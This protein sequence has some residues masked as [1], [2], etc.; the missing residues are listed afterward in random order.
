MIKKIKNLDQAATRIQK[1]I[2]DQENIII[3]GDVDPDG[4]TSV[5]ILKEAI[6]ALGGSIAGYYFP[7]RSREGYGLNEQALEYLSPFSPALIILVD[8]GIGN[9]KEVNLAKKKGFQVVIIDHHKVLKMPLASVV[10]DPHQSGETY[11]FH[12]FS[13][14]G[15]CY[16]LAQVLL[17]DNSR[18]AELERD[19]SE[20]ACLSTIADMMPL[21]KDNKGI[22]EEGMKNLLLTSRLSL[23][24]LVEKFSADFPTTEDIVQKVIGVLNASQ[25]QENHLA[26]SFLLLTSTDQK[27]INALIAR[28][29]ERSFRHHQARDKAVKMIE[30][31]VDEGDPIIFE[32]SREWL[33][34]IAGSVAS[35]LVK[36]YKKPIFLYNQGEEISTGSV[37]TPKGVDSVKLME[38]CRRLLISFGGHPQAS[39]FR[40]KNGNLL[41][42]KKCLE[43]HYGREE[44]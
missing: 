29:A 44:N 30:E 35:I 39:G 17:K 23:K 33:L 43:K 2:L 18:Q 3:Y 1:A 38:K 28:L 40:L 4:V 10:V 6:E 14:A 20:L 5:V 27:E 19:F 41:K 12:D 25:V 11:P 7:D 36:R 13:A 32:G 37:R 34:S 42:F 26:E 24:T 8:L 16:K 31:K 22:V 21:K 15:L 9:Y